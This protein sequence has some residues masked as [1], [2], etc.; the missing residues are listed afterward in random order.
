VD[1]L[2]GA[3]MLVKRSVLVQLEGFDESF[4]MYGEDIDLSYRIQKLGY[5]NYYFAGTTIIHFKG[6]STSK[7]TRRYV[8]MFYNAMKIFVRKH[9]PGRKAYVFRVFSYSA[10]SLRA[11]AARLSKLTLK[12]SKRVLD[13]PHAKRK[14][15][16]VG[17]NKEYLEVMSLLERHNAAKDV[18]GS[19]TINQDFEPSVGGINEINTWLKSREV[20]E[21]IFC[22]GVLPY[23]SIINVVQ[24]LSNKIS[25]RFHAVR[26]GSIVGSDSKEAAGEY[27]G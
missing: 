25:I 21:V 1:V 9:Y 8:D 11:L 15:I 3:F 18:I 22:N 19:F 16:V 17:T 20:E 7:G 26:S 12:A 4:F 13:K 24:Q 27:I 14:T 5:H 23:S 10:I 6:E 2:A